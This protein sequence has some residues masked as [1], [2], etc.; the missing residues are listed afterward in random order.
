MAE[1]LDTGRPHPARVYDFLL[2]GKDR[3]AVAAA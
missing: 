3:S 1:P 2:G